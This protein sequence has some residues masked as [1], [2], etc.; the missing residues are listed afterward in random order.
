[1]NQQENQR[2]YL[3]TSATCF[4]CGEENTAGL[5]T[6]FYVEDGVVKT[7]LHPQQHHCGYW[8]TVH[9]GVLAAIVDEC[10]GWAAARA[11][12]R[13]CVTA[14]LSIRYLRPVSA[15]SESS[16]ETQVNRVNRRLVEATGVIVDSDGVECV[17]AQGRF[18]PLSTEQTLEVDDNLIYRGGEERVFDALRTGAEGSKES[19]SK[20]T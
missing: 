10:M 13:M 8:N 6:R 5:R 14:E 16:V 1:M 20:D 7:V 4:V 15:D 18:F 2:V 17:R 11:I 12:G 3:P 19:A 9:G